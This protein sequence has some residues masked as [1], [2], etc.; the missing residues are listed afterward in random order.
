M[1][2]THIAYGD[3]DKK[4]A[5]LLPNKDMDRNLI[6][7]HYIKPLEALGVPRGEVVV[8]NLDHTIK[9]KYPAAQSKAWLEILHKLIKK[10]DI[11]TLLVCNPEYFKILA[12]VRKAEPFQGYPKESIWEGI[13]A[14][15]C[16][17]YRSL[18]YNPSNEQRIDLVL[19]ALG[20]YVTSKGMMFEQDLTEK[21]LYFYKNAEIK[22]ALNLLMEEPALTCDI[23]TNSLKV[24]EA[25]IISISFARNTEE[26]IAFPVGQN[27][28]VRTALRTF[29]LN[30]TGKLI[31]HNAPYDTKVLIWELF[32]K[33]PKDYTGMLEGLDA[34]YRNLED[35]KVIAYMALNTTAD[36]DLSLKSLAYAFAGNYALD[37]MENI[38]KYSL[39]ETL[40]YNVIDSLATWYVYN[41]HR[42]TVRQETEEAYQ[43]VFR[44]SLKTITL[45]E[46][47]GVP[48]SMVEVLASE[49]E[50]E[51]ITSHHRSRIM[52]HPIIKKVTWELR[53]LEAVKANKKLKKLR[54]DRN[55]FLDFEFNPGSNPQLAHLL[56]TH[57][58]LPVLELTK[59]KN[60]ST[61]ADVLKALKNHTND[62]AI[63]NMLEDLIELHDA[64][65][66]LNTFIK[67]FKE[68]SFVKQGWYYLHGSFNLGGT[69]SGRLSSS[70]PNLTNIP[71]KG[72]QYA[73]M[74]KQCF[75]TQNMQMPGDDYGWLLVGADY[76]SL[77]DRI[78]ALQ[79]KDPNKLK[80]YL[81]GYDGHCLRAYTYFG[82]Q[83][84]DINPQSVDSINSIEQKYEEIRQNS[85]GPTFLLT[86]MGTWKGL[87]KTFGFSK[88]E[89]LRIEQQYHEL[90]EVSDEWVKDRLYEAHKQGYVELAFGHRLRTPMLPQIIW[91]SDSIPFPVH[92]EMKTAGN[93]LGQSYGLLNSHS[94]NLFMERVWNS[95]W[96][97]EIFP[98]IQI[99]D[100]QYYL[101]RNKLGLLKWL[102]DNLVECMEWQDLDA[103]RHDE[104]GLGGTL[105]IYYPNW[106]TPIKIPNGIS[107][108]ALRKLLHEAA[109]GS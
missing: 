32:M 86:Y 98:V 21:C 24:Y 19:R 109:S 59:E 22:K 83:M 92:K 60:P 50:L 74:V 79:T 11:K 12:K 85:K 4:L 42:D 34:M 37:D 7:E 101:V 52:N 48:L 25:G 8:F 41:K 9:G 58:K 51:K 6:D 66:I 89:A 108:S 69:K 33:N 23:E 20:M 55:D 47:V 91:G 45:M 77:E 46:L 102:N 53:D 36:L 44:P 18:F 56:F 90:Y 49:K 72:T 67:A 87:M 107:K 71:S 80:V 16:P 54:K 103:I 100:S 57:L 38:A 15:V 62:T 13:T 94:S 65:K 84:P 63:Q 95:E 3:G 105:E 68:R 40:E 82:D 78:S 17:N 2:L 99:H 104:V 14:F 29:F 43:T 76:P 70:N 35:T 75:R 26:G 31:F 88:D 97:Y 28:V 93:A 39:S 106:A 61:K 27:E 96:R 10:S 5:I 1:Q 30:Y 81:D 73:K 64:E